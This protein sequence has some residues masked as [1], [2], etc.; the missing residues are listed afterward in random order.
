[1]VLLARIRHS[2]GRCGLRAL[3]ASL[4]LAAAACGATQRTPAERL[5]HA[6][7][8]AMDAERALDR[9]DAALEALQPEGAESMIDEARRALSDP[10]IVAYPEHS[11]LKARLSRAE[12][13]LVEAKLEVE[14]RAVEALIAEQRAKID[15]AV[16][17]LEAAV[18]RLNAPQ[19]VREDLEAAEAAIEEVKESVGADDQRVLGNAEYAEYARGVITDLAGPKEE[20]KLAERAVRLK[21]LAYVRWRSGSSELDKARAESDPVARRVAFGE[22]RTSLK[23]C[24]EEIKRALA[25]TPKLAKR[26][27][28][29]EEEPPQIPEVLAKRC[30]KEA[31][32][33][34]KAVAALERE[35]KKRE[36][37]EKKAAAAAAKKAA[38]KKKGK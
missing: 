23:A 37:R 25:A 26:P 16:S 2:S 29:I 4:C 33:I 36:A 18:G 22:A 24:S 8:Q 19:I 34:D 10:D 9:A 38:K 32:A 5:D 20:V 3:A 11:Q 1:M 7:R 28:A 27:L 14:R 6:E 31:Q 12:E 21:E 35:A 30:I 15:A 13:K 17:K